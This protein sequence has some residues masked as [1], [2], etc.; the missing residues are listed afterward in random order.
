MLSDMAS[1]LATIKAGN[2]G[3][4]T[5]VGSIINMSYNDTRSCVVDY[6]AGL[7]GVVA[8][9]KAGG[10]SVLFADVNRRSGWC[11]SPA[12]SAWPC[13]GVHPTSGGYMGMALAY[14][15][16]LAPLVPKPSV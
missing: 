2:P 13:T 4:T 16:V 11:D 9:A 8:T 5:I 14:F 6:N 15:E 12:S 3:A 7:P 1:L 10:Q